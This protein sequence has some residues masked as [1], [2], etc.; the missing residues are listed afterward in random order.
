MTY[1][2]VK[3]FQ[4]FKDRLGNW[5][6]YHRKSNTALDLRKFPFGSIQ[7]IAECARLMAIGG[8]EP[9]AKPGTLGLLIE[10]Y[11]GHRAFL[12]RAP[13]TRSDYQRCFDYLH[14]IRDTPL[15]KFTPPLVVKIRDKAADQ[16]GLRWGRIYQIRL[17]GD[18]RLGCGAGLHAHQPGFPDQEHSERQKRARGEPAMGG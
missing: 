17:V 14:A 1:V 9:V 13:R 8:K 6:C 2:K 5:R 16:L 18:F 4:I 11:R 10:R 7:F 3:G 15:L 12:D